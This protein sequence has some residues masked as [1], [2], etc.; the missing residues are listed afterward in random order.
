VRVLGT[1]V[2]YSWNR[3]TIILNRPYYQEHFQDDLIDVLDVYLQPD[4]DLESIRETVLRRWGAENALVMMTRQELCQ[5]ISNVIRRFYSMLYAQ[6]AVVGM[7]AIIG[8]VVALLISVLQRRRELGLIRAVGAS[9]SQVLYSVLAEATLMGLIG[10]AIGL[11]VGLP[12]EWYAIRVIVW[13]ESGF[14]FPVPIPYSTAAVLVS[15][16]VTLATLAGLVPALHAV[17]LRIPDA[18][19]Y[20]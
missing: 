16:A 8:V 9:Q 20:E 19:A 10:A 15:M 6:E 7:V 12:L 14:L 5:S 18:I 13:E 11:I 3:G 2:D 17:R 4:A 1:I